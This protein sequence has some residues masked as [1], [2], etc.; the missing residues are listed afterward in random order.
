MMTKKIHFDNND[1]PH[2]FLVGTY[3]KVCFFFIFFLH[4]L[5]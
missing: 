3:E 4:S 5:D 2:V 1:I